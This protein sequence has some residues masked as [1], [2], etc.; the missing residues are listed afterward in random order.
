[1]LNFSKGKLANYSATIV[2]MLGFFGK[3]RVINLHLNALG[4]KWQFGPFSS[5]LK[6]QNNTFSCTFGFPRKMD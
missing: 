4:N 3:M 5:T 6:V 1:M 2:K